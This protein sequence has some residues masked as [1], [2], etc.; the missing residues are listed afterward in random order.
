MLEWRWTESKCVIQKGVA[1]GGFVTQYAAGRVKGQGG[2]I[3]IEKKIFYNAAMAM[4]QR[5]SNT[6]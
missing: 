3:I 2:A 5:A 1:K 6:E 4:Y